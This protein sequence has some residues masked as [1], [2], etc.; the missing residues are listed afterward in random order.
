MKPVLITLSAIRDLT[1][2]LTF[3]SCM[4]VFLFILNVT[5]HH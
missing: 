3:K 5:G 4:A 1:I 2:D